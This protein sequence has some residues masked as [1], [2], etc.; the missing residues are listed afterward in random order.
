MSEE[1]PAVEETA[2][3]GPVFTPLTAEALD[4]QIARAQWQVE[5]MVCKGLMADEQRR[6]ADAVVPLAAGIAPVNQH[7]T[8]KNTIRQAEERILKLREVLLRLGSEHEVPLPPPSD[9]VVP[10]IGL[11]AS[12]GIRGAS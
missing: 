10:R 6:L 4:Q 11:G 8:L 5:I 7:G 1:G 3:E 9:I 2:E 12:R